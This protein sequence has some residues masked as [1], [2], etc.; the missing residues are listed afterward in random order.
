MGRDCRRGRTPGHAARRPAPPPGRPGHGSPRVALRVC[1]SI[2]CARRPRRMAAGC[3]GLQQLAH[4]LRPSL[5]R[6]QTCS[7]PPASRSNCCITSRGILERRANSND[8]LF[9][10]PASIAFCPRS[11]PSSTPGARGSSWLAM[12][13]PRGFTSTRLRDVQAELDACALWCGSQLAANP[14]AR[15][16]VITQDARRRRGQIERAFLE[17][18][19]LRQPPSSSSSRWEFRSARSLC[20]EPRICCCAGL[21]ARLPSTNS[22]GSFPPATLP[23]AHRNLCAPRAMRALRRGGLEQPSGP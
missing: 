16:L 2:S 23:P 21:P 13:P 3:G 14:R 20:H 7:A 17:P 22:T 8:R 5:P 6:R 4:R 11:E 15:L 9:C 18:H 10:W 12:K 19:R 1:A